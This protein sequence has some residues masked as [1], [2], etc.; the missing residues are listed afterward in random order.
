MENIFLVKKTIKICILVLMSD[1]KLD[2]LFTLTDPR[3]RIRMKWIRN[4]L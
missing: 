4:T 2:P 1:P 3:I